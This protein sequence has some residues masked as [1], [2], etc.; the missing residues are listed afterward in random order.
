MTM[1]RLGEHEYTLVAQRHA[2]LT[3]MLPRVLADATD[4]GAIN[5]ADTA[6]LVGQLG[7]RVYDVL[8]VLLGEVMP[9]WEFA[10]FASAE[11]MDA[12]AYDPAMDRSPTFEQITTAFEAA[13]QV[14]GM[15]RVAGGL[16]KLLG[17]DMTQAI[18]RLVAAQ[19]TQVMASSSSA[20]SPPVNG[21]SP[22]AS[23]GMSQ[24]PEPAIASG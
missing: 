13:W 22:S 4:L 11:A 24:Q 2:R 14:N 18:R 16:G 7:G 5:T 12:D 20:S 15:D 8:V 21:A 3:R 17:A 19:I 1:V 23:S 10:G 6:G 9:R